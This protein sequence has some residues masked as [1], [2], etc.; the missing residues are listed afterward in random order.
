MMF[1]LCC[2]WL[3]AGLAQHAC[4]A[5]VANLDLV[6]MRPA[7]PDLFPSRFDTALAKGADMG[8]CQG[9]GSI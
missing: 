8:F 3:M 6:T 1:E 7:I 4:G 9:G 2:A 5:G